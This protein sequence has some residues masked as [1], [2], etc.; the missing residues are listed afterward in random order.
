MPPKRTRS[1]TEYDDNHSF[2]I[3]TLPHRKRRCLDQQQQ[4]QKEGGVGE[5]KPEPVSL[6]THERLED[7]KKKEAKSVPMEES[8]H[9]SG[10]VKVAMQ[11][12]HNIDPKDVTYCL[13]VSIYV[14]QDGKTYR[15]WNEDY[16]NQAVKDGITKSLSPPSPWKCTSEHSNGFDFGSDSDMPAEEMAKTTSSIIN[17]MIEDFD[18]RGFVLNKHYGI[19]YRLVKSLALVEYC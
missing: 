16:L 3:P 19:G 7:E 8:E 13:S 12:F 10:E 4:Q 2:V 6:K 1:E 5:I 17:S 9:G 14:R 18:S 15:L 11:C